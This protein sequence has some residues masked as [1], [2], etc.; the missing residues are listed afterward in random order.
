MSFYTVFAINTALG[1]VA[2]LLNKSTTTPEHKAK[3][4][5]FVSAGQDLINNW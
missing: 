1:L 5:A 3:I 2:A 4:S